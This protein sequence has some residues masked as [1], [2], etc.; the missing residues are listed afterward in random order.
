MFNRQKDLQ[1]YMT[2]E[3]PS[4]NP[5]KFMEQIC[6]LGEEVGEVLQNDK[7]YRTVRDNK[8]DRDEKLKELA[9]VYIVVMNLFMWSGFDAKTAADAIN[10]RMQ[11]N[12]DRI[13]TC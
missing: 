13:D 10:D 2:G 7:R 4:D 1:Q 12:V 9:D 6:L 8:Y 11:Y 5:D 3:V